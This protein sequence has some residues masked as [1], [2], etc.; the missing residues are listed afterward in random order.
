MQ[1]A[2]K[3]ALVLPVQVSVRLEATLDHVGGRGRHPGDSTCK[4]E[5]K[6]N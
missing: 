2:V 4:K 1:D 5:K 3:N 6:N